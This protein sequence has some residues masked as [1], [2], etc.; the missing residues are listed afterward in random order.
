[1]VQLVSVAVEAGLNFTWSA[2]K[3]RRHILNGMAKFNVDYIEK[4]CDSFA[5]SRGC[6]F[7]PHQRRFIVA[8]NKYLILC[9]VLVQPDFKINEV[10]N[11]ILIVWVWGVVIEWGCLGHFR[12][13]LRFS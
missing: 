1:M 11:I 4:R 10:L 12:L 5:R 3:S 8:L 9:L 6:V 7:E 2:W 13:S